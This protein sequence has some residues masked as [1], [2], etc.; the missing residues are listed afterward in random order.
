MAGT[1]MKTQMRERCDCGGQPQELRDEP[2]R[3]T[4]G[5][6]GRVVSWVILA[7]PSCGKVEFYR[8]D[9]VRV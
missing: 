1:T 7:C 5:A 2:F 6:D 9:A 8:P 4:T 3:K